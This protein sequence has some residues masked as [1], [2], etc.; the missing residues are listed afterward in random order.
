[1]R[2]H[3][4]NNYLTSAMKLQYV[5]VVIGQGGRRSTRKNKI[6]IF[7]TKMLI[8]SSVQHKVIPKNSRNTNTNQFSG[9]PLFRIAEMN[10][11]NLIYILFITL[12]L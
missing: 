3:N 7:S 5:I 12:Y 1:M 2:A 4:A 6:S 10:A 11:L 8:S 9:S